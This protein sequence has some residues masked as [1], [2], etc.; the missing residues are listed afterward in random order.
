MNNS[1]AVDLYAN[2][3]VQ[4]LFDRLMELKPT[5]AT[6]L[7]VH[8]HD[9]RLPEGGLD[10][11]QQERALIGAFRTRLETAPQAAALDHLIGRYF[12]DLSL[13]ELD[14]FRLWSKMSEAPDIIGTGLY[15]LFVADFAPLEDRLDTIAS[16]LEDV[17]RYL[18]KSRERLLTPVKFWNEVAVR[19]LNRLPRFFEVIVAA[20][21]PAQKSRLER[22]ASA[23]AEAIG[24]Y[25]AW[26]T[27]SAVTVGS[28]GY[29]LGEAEFT[30]LLRLRKLPHDPDGLLR[31][32]DDELAWAKE[33]REQLVH[34]RADLAADRPRSFAIALSEYRRSV[35]TAR[36]FVIE[37]GLATVP[38]GEDLI[39][40]ETPAFLQPVVPFA[41]Y[42]PAAYF[43]AR[44]VGTYMI[45]PSDDGRVGPDTT[46]A[47]IKMASIHEGYPGHHLQFVTGNS[48]P[49]LIRLLNRVLCPE[50][51]E[52]WAHYC[53]DLMIDEGFADEPGLRLVQ[54]KDVIWRACRITIDVKLSCARM[55]IGDAAELLRR[56][57]GMTV[58]QAAAELSWYS[59]R[60]GYP[61]SYLYGKKLLFG[62]RDRIKARETG[63]FSLRAFHDRL[64]YAGAI[65]S[66]FWEELFKTSADRAATAQSPR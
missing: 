9:R 32:A 35:E 2:K 53:E 14:E 56:E 58:D 15:A 27:A 45:T 50:F 10:E 19:R 38:E 36:S 64:L 66:A 34:Q 26:L 61:L 55:S 51:V 11:V 57:V 59:F 20:A 25:A 4:Q 22:A 30:R 33:R 16:R 29:A 62:F 28:D 49:S 43:D 8:A 13:W 41:A 65:P 24:D 52:G 21:G 54:L 39:V 12:S 37:H 44:Q 60:P 46:R 31:L 63:E 48:H 7:G 17:P 42:Q 1:T 5:L 3:E 47:S 40:I 23:A 18:E 6:E